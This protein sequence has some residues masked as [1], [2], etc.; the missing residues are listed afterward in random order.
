[1]ISTEEKVNGG[2]TKRNTENISQNSIASVASLYFLRKFVLPLWRKHDASGEGNLNRDFQSAPVGIRGAN[3]SVMHVNGAC[4]D[5]QSEPCAA[6]VAIARRADA[7]GREEDAIGLFR[8]NAGPV[9]ANQ[10]A[11]M[12]GRDDTSRLRRSAMASKSRTTSPTPFL[13]ARL[14]IDDSR[15]ASMMRIVRLGIAR[16]PIVS[17]RRR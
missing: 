12:R 14:R 5:R 8:R 16:C 7:M 4:S 3:R 2:H 17:E 15:S 13:T 6:R 11:R 1:M 9:V 10:H